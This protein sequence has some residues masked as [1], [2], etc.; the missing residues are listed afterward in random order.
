[1]DAL[2]EEHDIRWA[3]GQGVIGDR[4]LTAQ[5]LI[6]PLNPRAWK[7]PA[8][9]SLYATEYRISAYVLFESVNTS[10]FLKRIRIRKK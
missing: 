9:N 8:S 5:L 2:F 1:V 6:L 10:R 7:H 3:N 4:R